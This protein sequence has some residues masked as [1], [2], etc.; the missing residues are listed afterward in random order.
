MEDEYY[1]K[2]KEWKEY[3]DFTH[4]DIEQNF[5]E[6]YE[7][8]YTSYYFNKLSKY[9]FATLKTHPSYYSFYEHFF[10]TKMNSCINSN[11]EPIVIDLEKLTKNLFYI[12]PYYITENTKKHL[13]YKITTIFL[14]TKYCES[15]EEKIVMYLENF[16]SLLIFLNQDLQHDKYFYNTTTNEFELLCDNLHFS[17]NL[18][19]NILLPISILEK[20]VK[21]IKEFKEKTIGK[22]DRLTIERIINFCLSLYELNGKLENYSTVIKTLTGNDKKRFI[23]NCNLFEKILENHLYLTDIVN[24]SN[25]D[26]LSYED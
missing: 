10:L 25:E 1:N 23:E 6:E 26:I 17:H 22:I 16:I 7:N 18:N 24:F 2:I 13:Y 21:I 4:V 14:P 15:E 20:K 19:Y 9:D 8:H 11:I 3:S 12:N 5:I